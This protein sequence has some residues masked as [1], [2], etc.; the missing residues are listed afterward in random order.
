MW[1]LVFAPFTS[2]AIYLSEACQLSLLLTAEQ[3]CVVWTGAQCACQLWVTV[4]NGAKN[5]HVQGFAWTHD[6]ISLRYFALKL[7]GPM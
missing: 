1:S 7:L 4:I 3:G 5:I 2:H 6:V